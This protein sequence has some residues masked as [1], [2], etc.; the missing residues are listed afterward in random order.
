MKTIRHL[1]IGSIITGG[2]A[3]SLHFLYAQEVTNPVQ[4]GAVSQDVNSLSDMQV[5]LQA[6]EMMPAVS[7]D[8]LPRFGTFYSAQHAPGTRQAWPP[9]PSNARQ[10]PVWDLGDGIYLMADQEVDYSAPLMS[11]R[12]AGGRMMDGLAP[13]GD[14]NYGTSDYEFTFTAPVYTTNDLWLKIT[15]KTNATAL[16][17]IHP[18]WNVTNGVYDLYYRTNL[19][20]PET[21]SWLL[22]S[23]A[24]QTNL[25]VNNATDAQGFYRLGP[26]NDLTA[27]DSLGTNFW[28][29]FYTAYYNGDAS[30]AEL[31]LYISSPV[32]ASGT[33]TIPGLGITNTFT[34]A[35]G[36]VTNMSIPN[37][38][39]L[40]GYSYDVVQTKGIHVAASQPVSVYG[41]Y[42][43]PYV[44]TAFTG[45]PVPLLGTNYCLM[46][47]APAGADGVSE[48]AIVATAD[49]TTVTITPSPT[50]VLQV[51]SGSDP[52]TETLQQGQTY[53]INGFADNYDYEHDVTGTWVTSDKP[54]AVF[55]GATLADVP[56]GNTFAANPLD[57][58]QLPVDSWGTMAL[59][60]SFAGRTNGDSYRVLAAYS[61]TV[62][63]IT[64][65]VVT[66]VDEDSSPYTVTTSNEVVV[67]TNQAGEFY[68]IIMD[69]PVEFQ[70]SQPIQVA[71]FANGT[72]F[73][74]AY[75]TN[76][77][78]D[79]CEILL[80][81]TGHYLETNTVATPV[82]GFDANYLN[83]IVAQSAISN[84]LVDG[85]TV[86]ASN[87]VAIG[88]S[89][90][91]GARLPV[92]NGTH[93]V[94]SSLPVGV[95][96]YGWGQTDA[97][98]YFGGVV[99]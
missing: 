32:G 61:N 41:L 20:P 3:A 34:V 44:S 22:R 63:T 62:V 66:P 93:K 49:N 55:A 88:S 50:A 42:Y 48:F 31:S 75:D 71:H 81:P 72:L 21:W 94:T 57:Q 11:S 77:D 15:G 97:Y 28:V 33:V 16:L 80:P 7:A 67:V 18:P 47:C 60:L 89:G 65:K 73:D 30:D 39:M 24:G 96:V 23:F 69:G 78:A 79:P 82:Q 4:G 29:A 38:A 2:L 74:H 85:S 17:T 83:I 25:M 76:D 51:S 90:Y 84:T 37:A 1:L 99:K 5:M 56:D 8:S 58:E 59:A 13:P 45:Y 91:Y 12:M 27:N 40:D 87:F 98:G 43:E 19:L 6:V 86:A 53:Q 36:A 54:I 26:P 14:G 52:Y 70:A 64:G 35:A 46:S 95:E 9:M 92:A 68:D 10:V